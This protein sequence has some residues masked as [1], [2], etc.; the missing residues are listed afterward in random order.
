MSLTVFLV[1]GTLGID[2]LIYYWCDR[3]FGDNRA[4]I[5]RKV[6]DLRAQF[7]ALRRPA[8]NRFAALP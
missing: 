1:F 2:F 5:A 6:A 4:M 7:P 3:A 8:E